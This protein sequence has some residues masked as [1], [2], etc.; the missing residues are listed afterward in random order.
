MKQYE[1][2]TLPMILMTLVMFV[3]SVGA[4]DRLPIESDKSDRAQ[5]E[6]LR[7]LVALKTK[8]EQGNSDAQYELG[9]SYSSGEVIPTDNQLA[10]HW[11]IQAAEKGHVRAQA[12]MGFRYALGNA[13]DVNITGVLQ[14]SHQAVYWLRKAAKQGN[15]DAQ[16]ALGVFLTGSKLVTMAQ[17]IAHPWRK[18][19]EGDIPSDYIRAVY[20]L[21]KAAEQGNANAQFEL[22]GMYLKGLGVIENE[23][24]AYA[25]LSLASMQ[26]DKAHGLRDDLRS[27]L[28]VEQLAEARALA[29]EFA[30]RIHFDQSSD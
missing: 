15:V 30:A 25:W 24:Q 6:R 14:D 21:R 10:V 27:R 17:F 26:G 19:L 4:E 28:T 5:L 11:I 29:R 8:A 7:V 1:R 22:G 2:A 20:W 23:I 16:F 13:E 3:A 12:E 9:I 18:V